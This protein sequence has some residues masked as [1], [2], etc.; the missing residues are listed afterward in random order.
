MLAYYTLLFSLTTGNLQTSSNELAPKSSI[1]I[2][3]LNSS[4]NLPTLQRDSPEIFSVTTSTSAPQATTVQ[5]LSTK[6]RFF[7]RLFRISPNTEQPK[8]LED[9]FLAADPPMTDGCKPTERRCG[10]FGCFE[11]PDVWGCCY[12]PP[13][14]YPC[15][16]GQTCTGEY[17]EQRVLI[18]GCKGRDGV[19]TPEANQT[20]VSATAEIPPTVPES[21]APPPPPPPST[22]TTPSPTPTPTSTPTPTPTP[23]PATSSSASSSSSSQ[24]SSSKPSPSTAPSTTTKIPVSSTIT[25]STP[26]DESMLP[27]RDDRTQCGRLCLESKIWTCCGDNRTACALGRQ[28]VFVGPEGTDTDSEYDCSGSGGETSTTS[29]ISATEPVLWQPSSAARRLSVP[30]V[31]LLPR[32]FDYLRST[33]SSAEQVPKPAR[34]EIIPRGPCEVSWQHLDCTKDESSCGAF[35]SLLNHACHC[36]NYADSNILAIF[37][38]QHD[39]HCVSE[40]TFIGEPLQFGCR[41]LD[42]SGSFKRLGCQELITGTLSIPT[43]A[44]STTLSTTSLSSSELFAMIASMPT[45]VEQ[46]SNTAPLQQPSSAARRLSVPKVYLL[47]RVFINLLYTRRSAASVTKKTRRFIVPGASFET[48]ISRSNCP[49]NQLKC[50]AF[51]CYHDAVWLCCHL[52]ESQGQSKFPC[53]KGSLCAAESTSLGGPI[54]FGCRGSD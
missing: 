11:V 35:G 13:N 50:G 7:P 24:P 23:P 30:K 39:T 10:A 6:L 46:L 54:V 8:P 19:F 37:P 16:A 15:R 49:P 20:R 27:C 47:P 5:T 51:G 33:R 34:Q 38:C 28:C 44:S 32:L 14:I 25:S 45:R 9:E 36:C 21:S 1:S 2:S 12:G 17:N 41:N 22:S 52:N 26:S 3:S 4:L 43:L 48:F 18:W 53:H 29:E 40:Y 31:Y 42:M